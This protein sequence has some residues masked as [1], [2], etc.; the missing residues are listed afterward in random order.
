MLRFDI[1]LDRIFKRK[2]KNKFQR[3][4]NRDWGR[5]DI[6]GPWTKVDKDSK[7]LKFYKSYY[8][9]TDDKPVNIEH[10]K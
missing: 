2:H 4:L 9:I 7:E 8:L 3:D 1:L 5:K 6:F 10:I